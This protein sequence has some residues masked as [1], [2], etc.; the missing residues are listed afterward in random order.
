MIP[1]PTGDLGSPSQIYIKN[2][3][4]DAGKFIGD[5]TRPWSQSVSFQAN[6]H[7]HSL[8]DSRFELIL[9]LSIQ[10]HQS[11]QSQ[12]TIAIDQAG[13]FV[14][15][16]MTPEQIEAQL[17]GAGCDLLLGYARVHIN[18]LLAEA[19]WPQVYLLHVNFAE[20]YRRFRHGRL[21][22]SDSLQPF[23]VQVS[24]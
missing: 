11:P 5:P 18:D 2:L 6:P 20:C 17:Y 16:Q 23:L 10:L 14:L 8:K 19:G 4:L 13:V 9:A 22:H 1:L 7:Y 15:R 24:S 21:E 3:R 12:A